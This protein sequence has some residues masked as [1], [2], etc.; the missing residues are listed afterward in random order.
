MYNEFA[1]AITRELHK[2]FPNTPVRGLEEVKQGIEAPCFLVTL[3]SPHREKVVGRL[4]RYN[5]SYAVQ[6]F[7]E[8]KATPREECADVLDVLDEILEWITMKYEDGN[9]EKREKL[10]YRDDVESVIVDD[11]LTTTVR[12]SDMYYRPESGDPME[13]IETEVALKGAKNG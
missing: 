7:P 1:K 4:Y 8:S 10:T 2:A 5:V 3:V 11:V 9:G 13:T 6:Y 12:Y